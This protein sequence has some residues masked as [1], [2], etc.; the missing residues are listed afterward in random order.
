[1]SRW[2]AALTGP[3]VLAFATV[4]A[5]AP[6]PDAPASTIL[7]VQAAV[8][9]ALERSPALAGI[10]AEARAL[11]QIPAQVGSLPDPRL[12]FNAIA[13]PTDTFET[14]QEPMTQLQVGVSQAIPFPG[15]LALRADAARFRAQAA[16]QAVAERRLRL[17]RDVRRAWWQTF[18]LDRALDTVAENLGLMRQFVQIAQTKYR[19]GRG[20]QQDVLLAQLELSRLLDRQVQLRAAR[21]AQTARL[22]ALLN[23]PIDTPIRLPRR[24]ATDLPTTPPERALLTDADRDR[25]LLAAQR[26]LI[27]AAGSRVALA[28]RDYLPDFTLGAAY[29][30]RAGRN[31]N[32]TGRVNLATF[33]F[34]MRIPL[35]AA[36]KQARAVDQ[37]DAELIAARHTFE[38]LR[39]RVHAQVAVSLADYRRSREEFVLFRTGILPQA[40][41]TVQ[42]MLAG[43]QVS[44]VDF[45]NLV[46]AQTTLYNYETRYWQSL[47]NARRALADL[48]AAVGK[49]NLP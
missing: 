21:R 4:V 10:R 43:Y 41:Q 13:L 6:L 27:A 32:G 28:R 45:L 11:A 14:G 18:Y 20:L 47:A 19:V 40:R 26:R 23:R 48:D 8:H 29:G 49:E 46:R 30:L 42:A 36:T 39:D 9:T 5:G 22:N 1:M 3:L 44:K 15:K 33:M 17:I 7:N 35:Y 16:D 25:P 2:F 24:S 38:D 12:S 31:P 37:R 34:S